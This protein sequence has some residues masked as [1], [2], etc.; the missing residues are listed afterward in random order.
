MNTLTFK[1]DKKAKNAGGDKYIC[2][3]NKEFSIYFPQN[4]S[5]D[6]KN[7]CLETLNVSINSY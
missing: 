5:R 4:I 7:E 2:T 6:D 3:D 1:L